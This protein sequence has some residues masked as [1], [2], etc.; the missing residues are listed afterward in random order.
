MNTRA[1]S[2]TV[3]RKGALAMVVLRRPDRMNAFN[4]TMFKELEDAAG[5]LS[6]APLPRAVIVTGAGS[7]AFCCG[8]DVNPDNPMVAEMARAMERGEKKSVARSIG[9]VRAAVD[10][11]AALPVPIIAAINGI[12]FGGGGRTGHSL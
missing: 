12:A 10:R 3:E 4:Q 11:F 1:E 9:V 8:F 2:I 6:S 5:E 7:K